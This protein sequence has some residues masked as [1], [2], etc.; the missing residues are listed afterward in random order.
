MF[1]SSALYKN[2]WSN[3]QMMSATDENT[4]FFR[5]KPING[6]ASHLTSSTPRDIFFLP[7]YDHGSETC[8]VWI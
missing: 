4:W 8:G 2:Y 3:G 6:L 5:V 1:V 7:R